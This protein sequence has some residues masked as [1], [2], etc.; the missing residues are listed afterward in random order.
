MVRSTAPVVFVN[1]TADPVDPPAN[2]AA[3]PRTMPNALLVTV[4]GASH[5]V[6]PTGCIPAQTTAFILAGKPASR[7]RWAACAR[8][9]GHY[10]PAFPAAP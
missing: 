8:T 10:Y 1:G 3:A 6:A 7:A 5:E 2:V 4:P 9:M